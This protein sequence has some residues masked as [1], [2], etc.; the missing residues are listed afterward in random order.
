MRRASHSE[1]EKFVELIQQHAGG[2]PVGRRNFAQR[3]MRHGTAFRRAQENYY[4]GG[5][6]KIEKIF[7]AIAELCQTFDCRPYFTADTGLHTMVI[8]VRS[9]YS[10]S[11]DKGRTGRKGILCPTS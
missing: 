4:K 1:R 3:L 2:D 8:E 10:N 7:P 5:A 11:L 6:E 9:G